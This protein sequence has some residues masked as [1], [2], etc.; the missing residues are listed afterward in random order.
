MQMKLMLVDDHQLFMEGLQYLLETHGINVEGTAKDGREA[1]IKARSLMPDIILMDIR[2]PEL[3]GLD[4]LKLIKAEMPDI[5][6]VM[7]TTSE[8]DGDIFDAIKYGAAGYLLKSTDAKTLIDMLSALENNE[9][10]LSPDLAAKL[11]RE[12]K[13]SNADRYMSQQNASDRTKN[14][15]LTERQLEVLDMVAKGRTYREVGVALG[16][17]E[18]TVKYHMAKILDQ[19]HLENRAQVIAY[20]AQIGLL[21]D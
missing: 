7:L 6:V 5:R 4:A 8:E 2:M 12:F 21:I 16:L 15:I 3:S 14:N 10:L 17:T 20:A 1:L 18:R 13:Y 11:L 9:T 19:L